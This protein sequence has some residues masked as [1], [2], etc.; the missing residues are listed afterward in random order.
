MRSW[1][2]LRRSVRTWSASAAPLVARIAGAVAVLLGAWA[3]WLGAR[4]KHGLPIVEGSMVAALGVGVLLLRQT[5]LKLATILSVL[6]A[7]L[8]PVGLINPF[9]AMD[10]PGVRLDAPGFESK[11]IAMVLA[12]AIVLVL[13]AHFLGMA[14]VQSLKTARKEGTGDLEEP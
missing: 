9:A 2:S 1:S 3:I 6:L 5:A 14:R 13:L 10:M 12:G 11:W 4:L 8:M 7:I